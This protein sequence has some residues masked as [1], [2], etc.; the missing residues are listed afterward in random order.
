[1]SLKFLAR[2]DLQ[3]KVN[4]IRQKADKNMYWLDSN[5]LLNVV[6]AH[7]VYLLT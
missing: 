7:L 5:D 3:E 4:R 2:A 6:N 1:M